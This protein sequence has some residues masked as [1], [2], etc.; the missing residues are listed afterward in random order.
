MADDAA[1]PE[2]ELSE[3]T[4]EAEQS[5]P[6]RR[7][8]SRNRR[9]R[10]LARRNRRGDEPAKVL[11]R[12]RGADAGDEAPAKPRDVACSARHH[13][14]AGGRGGAGGAVRLAR[15]PRVRVAQGGRRAQPVPPSR[16]AGRAEPHHDRL[17]A[18]RGRRAAHPG[19]RDGHLLRRLPV[20]VRSRS[21]RSSSRR[22]RN[23]SAPS[24]RP[25]SNRY[26]TTRPRSSS[27]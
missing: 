5:R 25:A 1:A 24:A 13:S 7:T 20:R 3:A 11:T 26:P 6:N 21:S 17:R 12:T 23:P 19:L 4:P 9:R 10:E 2:G 22:S 27:P 8:R 16:S 15:F 14:R 18:R